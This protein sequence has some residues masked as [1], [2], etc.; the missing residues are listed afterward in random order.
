MIRRRGGFNP[1][2]EIPIDGGFRFSPRSNRGAS[3]ADNILR[4]EAFGPC[5]DAAAGGAHRPNA[6]RE[7]S[8]RF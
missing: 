2:I 8:W 7:D 6:Q 3:N 4:R 5:R 1:I